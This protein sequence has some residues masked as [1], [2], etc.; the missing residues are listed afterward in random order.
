MH[1]LYDAYSMICNLWMGGAFD[2][3]HEVKIKRIMDGIV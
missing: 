1:G 2:V 3:T